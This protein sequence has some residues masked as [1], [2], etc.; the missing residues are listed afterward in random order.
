MNQSNLPQFL[1]AFD[2][3]LLDFDEFRGLILDQY[4]VLFFA[5]DIFCLSMMCEGCRCN[6]K[7]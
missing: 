1:S 5:G 2:F 6:R 3:I 4:Y 7:G